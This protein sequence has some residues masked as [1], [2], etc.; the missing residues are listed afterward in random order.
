M[1]SILVTGGLGFIGSHLVNHFLNNGDRVTLID[2]KSSNVLPP[3]Y[4]KP[5]SRANVFI[6]DISNQSIVEKLFSKK[7]YDYIFHFAANASVPKSVDDEDLNFRSNVVGTY[8]IVR[9]AIK[10]RSSI[11]FPSTSA[12]YGEYNGKAVQEESPANPISPYGLSKLIS[13]HICF[14]SGKVHNIKVAVFRLFNVYGPRQRRYVM[15]DFLDKITKGH[16]KDKIEMLG[17]GNEIR[18]FIDINDALKAIILPLKYDEMWGQCF[19]LGSG[20]GTKI[21]HVLSLMLKE[22]GL[23]YKISFSGKSWKGDI[24]GIKA[25]NRKLEALGFKPAIN[26]RI[27]IR[28]FINAERENGLLARQGIMTN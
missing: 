21:K 11:I 17:T 18:D 19:N 9:E 8:N 15:S 7:N 12:I 6:G 25:D 24:S 1:S 5:N 23:N 22:L 28:E 10:H 26:L 3:E 16:S 27:G 2:N 14:F 13:E 4:Y 20:N